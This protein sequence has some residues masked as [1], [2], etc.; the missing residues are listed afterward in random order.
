M[1]SFSVFLTINTTLQNK[2]QRNGIL[3]FKGIKNKYHEKNNI[4]VMCGYDSGFLFAGKEVVEK[5]RD[6]GGTI[7]F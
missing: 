1:F 3:F 5:S 2:C 7:G 4:N 6:G